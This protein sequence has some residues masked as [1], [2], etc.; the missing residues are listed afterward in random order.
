MEVGDL[1]TKLARQF[2]EQ[3]LS[4][5]VGVGESGSE[6]AELVMPNSPTILVR[7]LQFD[8]KRENRKLNVEI[9]DFAYRPVLVDDVAVSGL[10]IRVVR[11]ALSTNPEVLGLGMLFD[12]K[13]TRLR[14]GI[15]D[16]R[17]A[18]TYS[19][20]KGG[21]P[22][23]NSLSKLITEP[24]RLDDIT[25]RYFAKYENDFKEAIKGVKL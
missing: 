15:D 21:N 24:K 14:L 1:A 18:V 3:E 4:R 23:I 17:A 25:R 11:N 20:E 12:S 16:V 8:N 10:T 7:T 19:R 5:C 6:F 9:K 2:S 13:T 22:P